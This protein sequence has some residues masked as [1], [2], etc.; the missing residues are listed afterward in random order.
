MKRWKNGFSLIELLVVIAIIAVL[1]SLLLPTLARA[2]AKGRETV[3]KNNVRQL[4]FALS[5]HVLDHGYYPVY[6]I[7]PSVSVDNRF[8]PEALE[9]YTSTKWTNQLYRCPDYKG[10]TVDGNA[11]AS[12]LGS[13]GYNA[14]GTK[15]TP[16][17]LGLGGA[18]VKV[19][20]NE[21]VAGTADS[22]L[23]VKESKVKNP[24]DMIAIGDAHLIWSSKSLTRELYS[25]DLPNDN[26]SGMGLLDI[27]SR[28][29]VEQAGW[30][31]H[32]G[33][34]K[35]TS[36]R[37]SSRFSV[38]FCDAHV[39]GVKRDQLFEKSDAALKRWNNDNEYHP[40]TG[41]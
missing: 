8:W 6:N 7:D 36:K 20:L 27:N 14:N 31:G 37:H 25:V 39:E 9:D 17:E 11:D 18:L 22:I 15:F 29:G 30:P 26:F 4:A 38:A 23:R 12:P 13:Y 5:L 19:V 32:V 28:N 10:I 2:K 3:C 1:A 24:S 40:T 16:S 21:T 34:I 35:A 41:R 33:I